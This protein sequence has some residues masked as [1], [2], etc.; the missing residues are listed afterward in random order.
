MRERVAAGFFLLVASAGAQ[1][2]E[3]RGQFDAAARF[4]ANE[5]RMTVFLADAS[6]VCQVR[7]P[8]AGDSIARGA[9]VFFEV[10]GAAPG[11]GAHGSGELPGRLNYLVGDDR[12]R[13]T[14]DVPRFSAVAMPT[15][16]PGV[17]LEFHHRS[18][19]LEYDV[20]LAP[21]ASPEDVVIRVR[22][23]DAIAIDPSGALVAE[24]AVGTIRQERPVA[25]RLLEDGRREPI[26]CNFRILDPAHFGFEAPGVAPGTP[27]L[28]DPI[29]T[30]AGY[31]SGS[32]GDESHAIAVDSTGATYVA[33]RTYSTNFPKTAGAFD[34][35][36]GGAFDGFVSK[37]NATGTA[38][39]YST[40]VG[41]PG[42]DLV[43]S[44]VVDANGQATIAGWTGSGFPVTPGT[45][46]TTY[47][48]W[49][50]A[51]V[52]KLNAAGNGLLFATY[53]GGDHEDVANGLAVD[54]SGNL[55]L[56]GQT[57]STNFPT[58]P[59][60]WDPTPNG[61]W[62]GFVVKLNPTATTL[63]LGTRLGGTGI[64]WANDLAV[65]GDG[66]VVLAG[67]TDSP[68]FP[69]TSGAY[70]ITPN[71]SLDAF[72]ARISPTGSALTF[73][74]FLGSPGLDH[75]MDVA[76][77]GAG[78]IYVTG[79]ALPGFPTTPGAFDTSNDNGDAFVAKLSAAGS[80]LL[81]C[82][83]VGG[84]STEQGSQ[85]V[86]DSAGVAY[87]AGFTT[88][89]NFPVTAGAVLATFGGGGAPGDAF[90]AKIS[91]NGGRLDYATYFGGS[92]YE[93]ARGLVLGGA[94][95]TVYMAGSTSS[96][97]LPVPIGNF[98]YPFGLDEGFM[99]RFDI[100]LA[101]GLD[102]GPG[103]SPTA[104]VTGLSVTQPPVIGQVVTTTIANAPPNAVGGIFYSA[105]ATST[106]VNGVVPVYLNLSNAILGTVF[107]TSA[108]GSVTLTYQ[109]APDPTM[110]GAH[111]QEQVVVLSPGSP[112]GYEVSNGL[113]ITLGY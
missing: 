77:D 24:T 40:Y 41:A 101:S 102:L 18:G 39:V 60:A 34:L 73:A 50:E 14:V 31:L 53:V 112:W 64:D 13:W 78:A 74:T 20:V 65:A 56:C 63:L 35:T 103:W 76:L 10:V 88:S 4:V 110:A 91:A 59:G 3:N 15:V 106:T 71:G 27:M 45:F 28:I 25:F 48:G 87:V 47:N 11:A 62:D 96:Q 7:D 70:D 83:F 75:G 26:G 80:T 81:Y 61:G 72:V 30:Y 57:E 108:A 55:Y 12:S 32:N 58:S 2:V 44:I 37:V 92:G 84:S 19:A 43:S 113:A 29:L 98:D 111:L 16:R 99:A 21:G 100:P 68:N 85:I 93:E 69:A 97:N 109:L 17:S 90:L 5:G 54:A 105:P 23:A 67:S 66:S 1:F 36:L 94:A 82:T 6:F 49:K 51:F 95:G 79:V 86:V 104:P 42:G 107:T 46:D 38:L 89:M 52:A 9:N 22:G 33:G 8:V